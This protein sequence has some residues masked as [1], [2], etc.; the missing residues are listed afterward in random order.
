MT[1]EDR[2]VFLTPED[3]NLLLKDLSSRVPYGVKILIDGRNLTTLIGVKE[4]LIYFDELDWLDYY[5]YRDIM[6]VKPFLR[7]LSSMTD[8]ER[9]EL[10][11]LVKEGLSEFARFI[12]DGH[13]LSHDGLYMFHSLRELDWLNAHHFDYRGLISKNLAIEVTEDNNPYK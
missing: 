9:Q 12:E 5:G 3:K 13:G 10:Q 6:Y 4:D 8:E 7:P 2:N 1:S 11:E